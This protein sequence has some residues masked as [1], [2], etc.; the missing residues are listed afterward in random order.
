MPNSSSGGTGI[1][2]FLRSLLRLNQSR[3]WP[4]G[5]FQG[6]GDRPVAQR[7]LQSSA[8]SSALVLVRKCR[9]ETSTTVTA[10]SIDPHRPLP[11]NML[12]RLANACRSCP[13]HGPYSMRSAGE[14]LARP[15]LH[16]GHLPAGTMSK[17]SRTRQPFVRSWFPRRSRSWRRSRAEIGVPERNRNRAAHLDPAW[18][19]ACRGTA[20]EYR[21]EAAALEH[22]LA[23][24]RIQR[25]QR[26]PM[27]EFV[28]TGRSTSPERDGAASG[29]SR[30]AQT[31]GAIPG[32]SGGQ[33]MGHVRERLGIVDD[34][35]AASHSL[36][37]CG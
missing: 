8:S 28:E 10:P 9:N 24:L 15:A 36:I 14:E 16:G 1:P 12:H 31:E 18:W 20:R 26:V 27:A 33:D 17:K 6:D 32:G 4:R 30:P 37:G 34:R 2:R 11:G 23:M 21:L 29:A 5:H 35:R 22:A 19:E 3:Q 13:R 25:L 7:P